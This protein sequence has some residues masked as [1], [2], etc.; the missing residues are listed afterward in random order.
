MT[1]TAGVTIEQ[2]VAQLTE[3]DAAAWDAYG[4][5]CRR[6][7]PEDIRKSLFK[8][9]LETMNELAHCERERAH[10]SR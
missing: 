1:A 9:A 10:G 4:A 5:S 7:A 2:R 6:G 3:A 8:R